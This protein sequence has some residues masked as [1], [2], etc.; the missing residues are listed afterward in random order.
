MAKQGLFITFEGPE[1][2]GKSTHSKL[3]CEFLRRKSVRVLH[4]RE[5]G[6]T[7]ISEKIRKI[8]LDPENKRMDVI[9]EMLLY[10]AAR[11][12]IVKQK[13]LPALK[14][15]KVVVCDRFLDATLAYQGYAGGLDIKLIEDIGRLATGGLAPDLTFLLDIDSEQGLARAG[16]VKDRM[17][18]KSLTF[19]RSVRKGYLR[20]AKKEPARVKVMSAVGEIDETQENIRKIALRLCR[21]KI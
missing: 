19:H 21:S 17:E 10:M 1:G 20:I 16:N 5:P 14:Q 12:Q 8:L 15:G 2:S 4:T 9:T 3:L 7:V 11:S 13:I 6:G 18:R